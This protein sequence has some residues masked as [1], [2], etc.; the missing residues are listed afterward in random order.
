MFGVWFQIWIKLHLMTRQI[1]LRPLISCAQIYCLARCMLCG[2]MLPQMQVDLES[3]VLTV[4]LQL[5]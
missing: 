1:L 3:Q 5:R 2:E 4:L